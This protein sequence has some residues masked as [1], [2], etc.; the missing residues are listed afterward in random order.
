[1][2]GYTTLWFIINYNSYFR[3]TPFFW[4]SHFT[5]L[6]SNLFKAWWNGIFKNNFAG[7]EFGVL[8]FD[9]RCE[10]QV[11][12]SYSNSWHSVDSLC[13]GLLKIQT[14]QSRG[15]RSGELGAMIRFSNE[16]DAVG[17]HIAPLLRAEIWNNTIRRAISKA[18]VNFKIKYVLA[19]TRA[20]IRYDTK[21]Y[22]NVRSK[23]DTSQL[24]LPH[25]T[26]N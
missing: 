16:V 11:W 2:F 7:Q 24:N 6:C 14:W 25:G 13:P 21:C 1:M 12:L 15:L 19:F 23:A 5:R 8:F 17:A 22:F 26:N 3:V 10:A 20:T 4:H 18:C 9:S